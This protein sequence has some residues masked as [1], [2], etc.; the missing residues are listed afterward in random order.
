MQTCAE[1]GALSF[2]EMVHR[3]KRDFA[4][5]Q[6]QHLSSAIFEF[7]RCLV[8]APGALYFWILP[9]LTL[10]GVQLLVVVFSALQTGGSPSVQHDLEQVVESQLWL[11]PL[12]VFVV[13]VGVPHV[14]APHRFCS[15]FA[16]TEVPK[17]TMRNKNTY[18]IGFSSNCRASLSVKS[19]LDAYLRGSAG[20]EITDN[21]KHWLLANKPNWDEA[22]NLGCA[23]TARSYRAFLVLVRGNKGDRVLARASDFCA[24]DG[25]WHSVSPG[26]M[27][28][29]TSA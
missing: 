24:T 15:A 12:I 26:W 17:K 3:G 11:T 2:Y 23:A 27:R 13:L 22:L 25:R 20:E 28:R 19:L 9:G 18:A 5:K 10:V 1:I 8:V 21:C 4:R 7:Y 29:Y 6:M 16:A 14:A